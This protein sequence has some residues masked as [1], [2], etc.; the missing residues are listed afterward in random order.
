MALPAPRA[1]RVGAGVVPQAAD[2]SPRLGELVAHPGRHHRLAARH[3]Q[4]SQRIG[5]R[6]AVL[7]GVGDEVACLG[8]AGE[9][10][11]AG[12]DGVARLGEG[13]PGRVAQGPEDQVEARRAVAGG[14]PVPGDHQVWGSLE[15]LF[16]LVPEHPQGKLGVELRV[17]AAISLELPVL[18]VLDE[19]VVRVA[20]KCQRVEP[21]GVH[22]RHLQQPQPGARG[23]Q[24]GE[25]ELDEVV[26]EQEARP[27]G[28]IV[29]V[30]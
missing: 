8:V 2:Q 23:P 1:A 6:P 17:V 20:G 22:R 29:E 28:E 7:G 16:L 3:R 9:V 30:G 27:V 21:Q 26:A 18:V 13:R 10:L 12:A 25:V 19:V 24:M 15:E 11:Q 5:E 4:P 14:E